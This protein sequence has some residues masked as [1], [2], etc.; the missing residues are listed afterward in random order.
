V[1]LLVCA[2]NVS[3]GSLEVMFLICLCSQMSSETC[4]V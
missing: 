2:H 4:K 1:A 3:D